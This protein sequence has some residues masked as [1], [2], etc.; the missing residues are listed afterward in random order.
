MSS[1]FLLAFA[2]L[3]AS[4]G[5]AHAD[6]IDGAWCHERGARIVI[7]GPSVITPSGSHTEG[8]YTRH[9]FSYTVPSSDPGAGTR[10]NMLLLSE[11]AVQ[12]RMGPQANPET[13]HR[14]GPSIS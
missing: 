10:V 5:L 11:T 6:A 12:V 8:D 3:L 4:A 9:A 13:W 7:T 14:C 1:R 2:G